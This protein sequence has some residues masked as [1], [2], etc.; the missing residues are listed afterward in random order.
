MAE[1]PDN[2]VRRTPLPEFA[3]KVNRLTLAWRSCGRD[4]P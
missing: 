3:A 4:L 1:R 2:V